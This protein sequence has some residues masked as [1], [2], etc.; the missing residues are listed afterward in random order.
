MRYQD[1][2]IV[3]GS[4]ADFDGSVTLGMNELFPSLASSGRG[5]VLEGVTVEAMP[6]LYNSGSGTGSDIVQFQ[7]LIRDK[8]QNNLA[9]PAGPFK[10]ISNVNPTRYELPVRK[11]SRT[12][13]T[14][15]NWENYSSTGGKVTIAFEPQDFLEPRIL[16]FRVTSV[17]TVF[18]QKEPPVIAPGFRE[19]KE[20]PKA[21]AE[22]VAPQSSG[23]SKPSRLSRF[24]R[25]NSI[26][27]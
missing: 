27:L 20:P 10:V 13:P 5:G 1:T 25:S 4:T 11:M 14:L 24:T 6:T 18:P 12:I 19:G 16:N 9:V 8:T 26:K 3:T 23:A 2:T 22:N 7:V 17:T 21:P 15:M